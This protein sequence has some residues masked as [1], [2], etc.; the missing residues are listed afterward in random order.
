MTPPLVSVLVTAFNREAY[1]P[2]SIE[3]VLAQ[4]LSDFELIITDDRS[5]DGTLAVAQ[6]YARR[7]PR[8]RV[9]ANARNLGDYR[10]RN[11]AAS[12]ASGQFLKFHDSDDIMYPHCLQVMTTC[13][14]AEPRAGLGL[15]TGASWA[16]GPAPMLSTPRM[17]YQRE[18][19]GYGAFNAGPAGALFR[20]NVFRDLSGFEDHGAASDHLFWLRACT[21]YPVLLLPGDLFWYRVHSGQ[22][23]QSDAAAVSYAQVPKLSWRAL[24]SADCPLIEEERERAKKNLAFATAKQIWRAAMSGHWRIA[25]LRLRDSGITPGEW[26]AYLRRPQRFALAGTPLDEHGGYAIPAW[27]RSAPPARQHP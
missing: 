25:L 27:C 26:L 12:L 14:A 10:N 9:H 1:L 18:F 16:G 7:D 21:K 22:S 19:L 2:A 13:L 8:I 3:S 15:S 23:F 17:S 11:H 5:S 24:L 20:T 4:S 6:E